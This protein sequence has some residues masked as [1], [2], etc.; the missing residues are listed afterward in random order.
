MAT[1]GIRQRHPPDSAAPAAFIQMHKE[2][3]LQTPTTEIPPPTTTRR[4]HVPSTTTS[5]TTTPAPKP[6]KPSTTASPHAPTRAHPAGPVKHSPRTQALRMLA[7]FLYFNSGCLAILFTQAIGAPLY[8]YDKDWFYAWMAY[9]K[10]MFGILITTMTY[11]WAPVRMVVCGD[12]SM[13]GQ[14]RLDGEGRLV[15][16]FPE[17]LVLVANHQ[18]YTDWVYLWWIA[19][20]SSMHG[21]L[22]IIL[23]ESIQWIPLIGLGM[24]LYGFIFVSRKWATDE[25]RMAYRLQKLNSSHHGPL[26]G[27]QD[28]DPMWL[29]I[30]PEGTNLSRDGR[31]KSGKWADKNGWRDLRHVMWPR[32]TGTRYC[33][34]E[35]KHTTEWVY[36]CTVAYEGVPAGEFGQDI[37]TLRSTYFQGRP[38]KSVHMH[39]RRFHTSQIPLGEKEFA[40]WLNERWR[41]K[42]DLI[43]HYVQTGRFPADE[44]SEPNPDYKAGKEGLER[45]GGGDEKEDFGRGDMRVLKGAGHLI[46][47]VKPSSPLEVFALFIPPAT[48][49]LCLWNVW[50]MV[51][52]VLVVGGLMKAR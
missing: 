29:L 10:R 3:L 20:T 41:E 11:W 27:T 37:F 7:F 16:E 50:K 21:H 39:W 6:T 5:S 26:S 15:C 19:Y 44:G 14:M 2:G 23:K 51:R 45:R 52:M 18:I 12:S 34:Q 22:Y 31:V 48:F 42:D 25:S 43:E 4:Q 35:L 46:T 17:R 49:W 40:D 1:E 24:K 13:R 47:Q 8:F 32:S 36:D 28:L 30:F 9:T 38:P 33:V